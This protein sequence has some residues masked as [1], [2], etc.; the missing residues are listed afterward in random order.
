MHD[1]VFRGWRGMRPLDWRPGRDA[2]SVLIHSP[3]SHRST[4]PAW[5]LQQSLPAA[6]CPDGP[7]R[8]VQP[9][10]DRPWTGRGI[11]AS[12]FGR[13]P[14]PQSEASRLRSRPVQHP[15]RGDAACTRPC[16][17]RGDLAARRRGLRGRGRSTPADAT[18][19][20]SV[21]SNEAVLD[22]VWQTVRDH[23]YDPSLRGLDWTAGR[24]L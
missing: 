15:Q 16:G 20:P 22:E 23:F 13:R 1:S 11:S 12:C 8:T 21:G 5:R 9:W 10:L 7:S 3:S 17:Q 6:A 4:R 18:A 24:A 2:T 14:H 19:Q